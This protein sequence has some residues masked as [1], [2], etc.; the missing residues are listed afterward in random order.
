MPVFTSYDQVGAKED[1]SDVITN[2]SPTKVPFQSGIGNEKL[3]NKVFDWQEDSLRAVTDNNQAEGFDATFITVTPT[4]MRENVTQIL[5][6]AFEVAGTT[7]AISVY[8]RAKDSALQMK[9][10][11]A[12]VKRDLE[13]AFVGTA[14]AKVK[15]TDNTTN[16]KMAGYQ[17][18]V[19]SGAVVHSGASTNLSEANVLTLLQTLYNNGADPSVIMVTPSNSTI[20]ADFAKASGRQ[21]EII[22]GTKDRA[23][24]NAVD[25]YVSPF[26]EQKVVLNRFL[27]A[28]NTLVYEP[29]MWALCTLRPWFRETLAK[30]G[31]ALK[32]MIVGEF[33][34]KHK[35]FKASG[36]I[37]D[38]AASG[39]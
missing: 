19:D 28:H 33:S 34:L 17:T 20:V 18:Q 7:D 36:V 10:S 26:G 15:P 12:Q 13:N 32:M 21:R 16:R 1:V 35:N 3:H 25:L 30:T 29:D 31:D 27:K 24:V 6:E 8:G 11:S 2:I 4:V 39:F 38:N 5:A 37:V 14:Q 22:N 9:K 23:V